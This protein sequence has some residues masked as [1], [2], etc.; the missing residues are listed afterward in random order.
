MTK[1][2]SCGII[3]L[4]K[5]PDE[6]F[7]VLLI[8]NKMGRHRSFPKGH[9]E[10]GELPMETAVRE[11]KEETGLEFVTIDTKIFSEQHTFPRREEMI[12]KHVHY[13]IGI[14]ESNKVTID[15]REIKDYLRLPI[16]EAKKQLT[17]FSD[18]QLWD[19]VLKYL[20]GK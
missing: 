4:Y 20:L 17:F 11:C 19:N 14:T 12:E 6:E 16:M 7:E 1:E 15:P 2:I 8:K 3:P 18:R 10:E 5:N 13:F 9:V